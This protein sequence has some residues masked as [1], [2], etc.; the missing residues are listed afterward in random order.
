MYVDPKYLVRYYRG[1][2]DPART[3]F[4][5]RA[6]AGSNACPDAFEVEGAPHRARGGRRAPPIPSRPP[7]VASQHTFNPIVVQRPP[8]P[9]VVSE[10]TWT[11]LTPEE[12]P[13]QDEVNKI[14]EDMFCKDHPSPVDFTGFRGENMR[15]TLYDSKP[16]PWLS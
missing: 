10:V 15:S 6:D 5:R 12:V 11:C 14:L 4:E 8:P 13:Y 3:P 16:K 7:Q 2:R 9:A 1:A